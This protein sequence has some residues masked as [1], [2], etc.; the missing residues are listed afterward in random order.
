MVKI[1]QLG[2]NLDTRQTRVTA[3]QNGENKRRK[4]CSESFEQ[5][6][7]EQNGGE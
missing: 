7:L 6:G 3:E 5:D 1:Q 2:G 4:L